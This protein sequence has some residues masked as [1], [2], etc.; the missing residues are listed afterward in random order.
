M[1][2]N[3]RLQFSLPCNVKLVVRRIVFDFIKL[4]P[5]LHSA[6]GN[7]SNERIKRHKACSQKFSCFVKL[8]SITTKSKEFT[9]TAGG[10]K[11]SFSRVHQLLLACSLLSRPLSV[12]PTIPGHSI[13]RPRSETVVIVYSLHGGK[14]FLSKSTC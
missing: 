6:A 12:L 2:S 11:N 7:L 4:Q 8:F 10:D 13:S 3:W 14:E 5:R 9:A 1:K